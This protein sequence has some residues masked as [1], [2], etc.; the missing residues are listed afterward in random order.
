MKLHEDYYE[1]F[2]NHNEITHITILEEF[3]NRKSDKIEWMVIPAKQY[4]NAL[5]QYHRDGKFF[6]F[7]ERKLEEWLDI[8]CENSIR[9]E[10][11][12]DFW[13]LYDSNENALYAVDVMYGDGEETLTCEQAVKI[14]EEIGFY[15]WARLPD[16]SEGYSDQMGYVGILSELPEYPTKEEMLVTINRCIDVWHQRGDMAAMLIEGGKETARKITLGTLEESQCS[17]L[18]KKL[19]QY[20]TVTELKTN[21][22]SNFYKWFKDSKVVDKQGKPLVVYHGTSSP[23]IKEFKPEM[24]ANVDAVYFSDN[25]SVAAHWSGDSSIKQI[26]KEEDADTIEKL[27]QILNK[28][29]KAKI[30]KNEHT[31]VYWLETYNGEVSSPLGHKIDNNIFERNGKKYDLRDRIREEIKEFVKEANN[32]SNYACYLSIQNPLVIDAKK[33]PYW[34][35]AFNGQEMNTES[36]AIYAQENGYDGVIIKNVLET[37]YENK[38]CTDYIV[39]NANQIKSVDNNG[40]WSEN[41]DNIY[42]AVEELTKETLPE[43]NNNFWKWFGNSKAVDSNGNPLVVYHGTNN[44]FKIFDKALINSNEKRGDYLGEGFYFHKDKKVAYNYGN[45]IIA[46]Y[47]KIEN[48]LIINT[49]EDAKKFRERFGFINFNGIKLHRYYKNKDLTDTSPKYISK[50]VK[51]FG[52]DGLIDNLYGQYAVFESNQIK[53]I[54]NNGKWSSSKNIYEELNEKLLDFLIKI[55]D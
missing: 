18:S 48:P 20:E 19:K 40:I 10:L 39:F 9:F 44:N 33:K 14:L 34:K 35:I 28:Y 6:K 42:E 45:N 2:E 22:N 16:G 36:I 5:K 13:C 25:L 11:L 49:E 46:C 30:V 4:Y 21:L 27:L 7:P 1:Q 8:V 51:E 24:G 3:E 50:K 17:K 29:T 37:D 53:S 26:T 41:S 32:S 23:N 31:N 38:L 47:L 43:L 15:D 52:Y 54:E 12:N 55:K